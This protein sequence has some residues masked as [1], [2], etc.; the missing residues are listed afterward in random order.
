MKNRVFVLLSMNSDFIE[1]F[2]AFLNNLNAVNGDE[3]SVVVEDAYAV[4]DNVVAVPKEIKYDGSA[5]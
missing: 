5:G 3:H 2:R 4:D 1:R